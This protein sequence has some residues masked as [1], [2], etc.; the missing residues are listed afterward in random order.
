[1]TQV[2]LTIGMCAFD[3][4]HGCYFTLQSIRMH[5]MDVMDKVE[6]LVLDNNPTSK[7]GKKLKELQDSADF[8]RLMIMQEKVKTLPFSDI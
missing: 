2:K 3:D 1:M 8:S 7:H 4:Y 5:H 6:L